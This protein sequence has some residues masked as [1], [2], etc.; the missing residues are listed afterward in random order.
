MGT[1]TAPTTR[2]A[3]A[4]V[5]GRA[6]DAVARRRA[7]DVDLLLAA[8]EWAETHPVPAGGSA[9][10]WGEEDFFGEGVIPLAGEGTPLV[11]EFA[12]VELAVELRRHGDET[13]RLDPDRH[14]PA[15]AIGMRRSARDPRPSESRRHLGQP[16]DPSH[17]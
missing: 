1:S 12:P 10:E 15:G 5:L 17:R 13:V 8:I 11:A 9:A 14:P 6:L 3:P 7:A 16:P 4:E 2:P